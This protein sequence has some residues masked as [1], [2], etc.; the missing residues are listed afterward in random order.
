MLVPFNIVDPV[1]AALQTFVADVI[2]IAVGITF[3]VVP[4]I[5]Q[6]PTLPDIKS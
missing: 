4:P 2:V 6:P 1:V 5:P 3:V